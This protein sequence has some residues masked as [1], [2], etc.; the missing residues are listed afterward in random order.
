MKKNIVIEFP[1]TFFVWVRN[2]NCPKPQ[3]IV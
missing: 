2:P 3:D 1:C